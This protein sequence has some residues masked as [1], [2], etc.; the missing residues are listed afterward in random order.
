MGIIHRDIK[1]GNVLID[2]QTNIRL[3]DFGLSY[4][5]E[6]RVSMAALG[7]CVYGYAGTQGYEAPEILGQKPYSNAVDFWSF[8]CLVFDMLKSDRRI[9][10]GVCFSLLLF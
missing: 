2:W 8:G 3:A 1:P 6:R 4:V 9:I 5:H 7:P 10:H